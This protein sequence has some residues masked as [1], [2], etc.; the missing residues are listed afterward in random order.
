MLNYSSKLLL[1]SDFS[2]E[3]QL[4]KKKFSK[5]VIFVHHKI[6]IRINLNPH[7]VCGSGSRR[8]KMTHK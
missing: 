5:E 6:R 3:G 4:G 7:F 8:A 2:I 1:T